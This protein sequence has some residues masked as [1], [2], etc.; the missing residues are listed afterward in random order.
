[1]DEHV[2]LVEQMK[3]DM[4]K[5]TLT[6]I[7]AVGVA[8][9]GMAAIPSAAIP[10]GAAVVVEAAR[11]A[12]GHFRDRRVAKWWEYVVK[13]DD[14]PEVFTNRVVEALYEEQEEI[15]W[16]F[17]HG[18]RAA[19]ES[20]APSVLPVLGLLSRRFLQEQPPPFPRWFY[21]SAV[22][23]ISHLSAEDLC[24]VRRM[25]HDLAPLVREKGA[26]LITAYEEEPK[27]RVEGEDSYI[28]PS[29]LPNARHIFGTLKSLP[30]KSRAAVFGTTAAF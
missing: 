19:G 18:A 7:A 8:A 21:R 28:F 2:Y 26:L 25:L 6:G 23:Y 24:I 22:T 3:K 20:V 11:G 9:A 27:A 12:L 10:A 29:R 1:M 16:A 30:T 13:G 5:D 14:E 17:I 4:V 15:T